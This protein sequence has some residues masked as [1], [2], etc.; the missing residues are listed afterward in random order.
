MFAALRDLDIA[1][2]PLPE[3]AALRLADLRAMTGLKMPDCCALLTAEHRGARLATF[4]NALGRAAGTRG[5]TV[6]TR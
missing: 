4:D 5:L 6:I 1:E 2:E 3:A